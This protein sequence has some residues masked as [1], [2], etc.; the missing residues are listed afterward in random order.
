MGFGERTPERHLLYSIYGKY[1]KGT[2]YADVMG[3]V[4]EVIEAMLVKEGFDLDAWNLCDY[5]IWNSLDVDVMGVF[6]KNILTQQEVKL[7][8]E[9]GETVRRVM[10]TKLGDIKINVTPLLQGM[11]EDGYYGYSPR[12]TIM[13]SITDDYV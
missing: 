13:E 12:P 5:P 8:V 7:R 4:H 3:K 9:T 10:G 11:R 1:N 6:L 2:C